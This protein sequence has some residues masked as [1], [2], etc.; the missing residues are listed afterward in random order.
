MLE[1]PGVGAVAGRRHRGG[2]PTSTVSYLGS[3]AT[4]SQFSL[5]FKRFFSLA[6]ETFDDR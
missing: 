2:D 6:Q 4:S 5:E 3:P 1:L